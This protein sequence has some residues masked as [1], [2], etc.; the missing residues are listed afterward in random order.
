MSSKRSHLRF[1]CNDH[2]VRYRTAYSEGNGRLLNVSTNGCAFRG[3]TE[4]VDLD[5]TVL[6]SIALE[7]TDKVFE[8]RGQ[9]VR[10]ENEMVA[11]QYLVVEHESKS[12]VR[13]YFTAR[14][15]SGQKRK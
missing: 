10:Q 9:V 14:L 5:E 12:L 2:P 1:N 3:A 15:R 8:A 13:N 11:V 6:I 4:P 7:G